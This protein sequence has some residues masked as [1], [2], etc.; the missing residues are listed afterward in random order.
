MVKL[1]HGVKHLG[2]I[3]VVRVNKNDQSGYEPKTAYS[4]F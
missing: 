3:S 4:I 1:R 2:V